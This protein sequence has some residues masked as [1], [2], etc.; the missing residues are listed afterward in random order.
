MTARLQRL[1]NLPISVTGG[2][3]LFFTASYGS[4]HYNKLKSIPLPPPTIRDP[5]FQQLQVSVYDD[6]AKGYDDA[7]SWDEFFMGLGRRRK[8]VTALAK[9]RV[10]EL[11]AGTGR[12]MS[13]YKHPPTNSVTMTDINTNMLEVAYYKM[14]ETK[15]NKA[16]P[17][18]KLAVADAS[19]LPFPDNSFDTVVDCFGLCSMPDPVKCLQ[20]MNRVVKRDGRVLLLEHGTSKS[21]AFIAEALDKEAHSHSKRWGCWWNREIEGLVREAGLEIVEL[22]NYH[23]GTTYFIQARK[24]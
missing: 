1:R 4:Y 17:E 18:I 6:I 8:Q 2:F 3:F 7:I 14:K 10:L 12:N 20:E 16:L 24:K 5:K 23:F 19:S 11:A 13:L 9:G 22:K 21:Y 15:Q